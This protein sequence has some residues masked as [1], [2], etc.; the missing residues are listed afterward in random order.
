MGNK[1]TMNFKNLLYFLFTA[2]PLMGG[3][4]NVFAI[5]VLEELKKQKEES[6]KI[7]NEKFEL[8]KV[9]SNE[10]KA[11]REK[12]IKLMLDKLR[13][14]DFE[15]VREELSSNRVDFLNSLRKDTEKILANRIQEFRDEVKNKLKQSVEEQ[16]SRAIKLGSCCKDNICE[17]SDFDRS[18]NFIENT[19]INDDSQA[20]NSLFRTLS[21]ISLKTSNTK[22]IN[23]TEDFCSKCFKKAYNIKGNSSDYQKAKE[24]VS[25]KLRERKIENAINTLGYFTQFKMAI[26]KHKDVLNNEKFKVQKLGCYV[27]G[28]GDRLIEKFK[29]D[30]SCLK[31]KEFAAGHIA[32]LWRLNSKDHDK[33]F[34]ALKLELE[35]SSKEK[36][37]DNS[38]LGKTDNRDDKLFSVLTKMTTILAQA[39]DEELNKYCAGTV[40]LDY[41]GFRL[42]RNIINSSNESSA[43]KISYAKNIISMMEIDSGFALFAVDSINICKLA[44][45]PAVKKLGEL[46]KSGKM[47]DQDFAERLTDAHD[48]ANNLLNDV[49]IK[50]GNKSEEEI[51]LFRS[52]IGRDTNLEC[53]SILEKL[54]AAICESDN[55]KVSFENISVNLSDFKTE[56]E[57]LVVSE[58]ACGKKINNE[59]KLITP[60]KDVSRPVNFYANAGEDLN[61]SLDKIIQNATGFNPSHSSEIRSRNLNSSDGNLGIPF[62]SNAVMNYS[63][64]INKYSGG[65]YEKVSKM[66]NVSVDPTIFESGKSSFSN[67]NSGNS[68]ETG[69]NNEVK[70]TMNNDF[71]KEIRNLDQGVVNPINSQLGESSVN[72]TLNF[73]DIA[74]SDF[75]Q[76]LPSLSD[77][78]IMNE[79]ENVQ[80]DLAKSLGTTSENAQKMLVDELSQKS[81]SLSD[82]LSTDPANQDLLERIKML[83]AQLAKKVNKNGDIV[84]TPESQELKKANDR[85]SKLENYIAALE[86]KKPTSIASTSGLGGSSSRSL[87]NTQTSLGSVEGGRLSVINP[88]SSGSRILS[89]G[90]SDPSVSKIGEMYENPGKMITD[91]RAR[92]EFSD[93]RLKLIVDE[94]KPIPVS[95]DDVKVQNGKIVSIVFNKKIIPINDV[96][97][98]LE[99]SGSYT[100]LENFLSLTNKDL[101]ELLVKEE[102]LKKAPS[103]S[104]ASVPESVVSE[105]EKSERYSKFV[106]C[107]L[108]IDKSNNCE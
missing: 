17:I 33:A 19:I 85:I 44:S 73:Q 35:Q 20:N 100:A 106:K 14:H 81:N 48:A 74:Q 79:F 46:I 93:N 72:N 75:A 12:D 25:I 63:H 50:I 3:A 24:K 27:F 66:S 1:G 42:L 23:P 15:V 69:K 9:I 8:D 78:E 102:K 47:T 2:L 41:T 70:Y 101:K 89:S 105:S 108:D 56:E 11:E 98:Q 30:P 37:Y 88:S 43:D 60:E 68:L 67:L 10:R 61:K 86:N 51:R 62:V 83:E 99:D 103:R 38:M 94:G 55:D 80:G 28:E 59:P 107:F 87:A 91:K 45:D 104:I 4:S 95:L 97:K 22:G 57:K 7:R 84:D 76:T 31:N 96:R 77:K 82:A 53:T 34:D 21:L 49:K 64:C 52:I 26:N 90:F 65:C 40:R 54:E 18:C 5:D 58:L 29:K 13:R 16:S 92:F 71:S 6:D 32:K 39:S 36:K